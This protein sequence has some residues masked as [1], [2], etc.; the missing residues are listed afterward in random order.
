[1]PHA[2]IKKKASAL[3]ALAASGSQ[4]ASIIIQVLKQAGIGR[5]EGFGATNGV[6][7]ANSNLLSPTALGK[8][9]PGMPASSNPMPGI[10]SPANMASSAGMPNSAVQSV[11]QVSAKPPG[12]FVPAS[13]ITQLPPKPGV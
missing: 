7:N 11:P 12:N 3:A 6:M 2:D 9:V 4:S 1:M 13:P 8:Q 5:H 10:S